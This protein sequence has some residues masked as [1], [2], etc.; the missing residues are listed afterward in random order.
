MAAGKSTV[1]AR[2]TD[3]KSALLTGHVTAHQGLR[4]AFL[5]DVPRLIQDPPRPRDESSAPSGLG[6][7]RNDSRRAMDRVSEIDRT[8]EI[9]FHNAQERERI[10]AHD[11]RDKPRGDGET[12]QTMSNRTPKRAGFSRLVIDMKRCEVSGQPGEKDHVGLRNRPAW[13]FPLV[14]DREILEKQN[15]RIFFCHRS[16]LRP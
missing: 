8:Q 1:N 13:A 10:H 11:L 16:K 15:G 4:F 5:D 7:E 2:L 6:L 3:S 14:A 12:E 9:P